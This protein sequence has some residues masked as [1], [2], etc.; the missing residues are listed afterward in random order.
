MERTNYMSNLALASANRN[1]YASCLHDVQGQLS[2]VAERRAELALIMSASESGTNYAA[3]AEDK[4]LESIQKRLETQEK[5]IESLLKASEDII[6][7]AA[8]G[9]AP[10]LV[11]NG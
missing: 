3:E 8:K 10:K 9:A 7:Q 6:K 4:A 1:Y 5:L 2:E 11:A